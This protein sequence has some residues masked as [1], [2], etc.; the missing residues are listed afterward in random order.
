VRRI[1]AEAGGHLTPEGALVVEVGTGRPIL[2][3][4]YPRLPFLWLDTAESEGEV[5][6]LP[7]AALREN[8]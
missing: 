6:A 8:R 1:L 3:R 4:E 2:E 5:F 7:A